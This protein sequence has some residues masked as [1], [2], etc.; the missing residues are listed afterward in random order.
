MK[1]NPRP[2][3]RGTSTCFRGSPGVERVRER[4]PLPP[5]IILHRHLFALAW[6]NARATGMQGREAVTFRKAIAFDCVHPP[7]P[8]KGE[9]IAERIVF[10]PLAFV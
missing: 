6:A 5:L 9:R 7:C 10:T 4:S 1:N 2:T 8:L 3:L